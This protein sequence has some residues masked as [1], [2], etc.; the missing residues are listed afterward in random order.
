M[1]MFFA[2]LFRLD[3]SE[4]KRLEMETSYLTEQN[5]TIPNH[6]NDSLTSKYYPI[7]DAVL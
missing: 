2:V 4:G 1:E 7:V 5:G 3:F 6:F